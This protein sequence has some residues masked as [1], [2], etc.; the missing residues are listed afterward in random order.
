LF[1]AEGNDPRRD[2]DLPWT[3]LQY[4]LDGKTYGVVQMNSPDNP[5]DTVWS[6][7]RDYGRFGAFP[8]AEIA[9]GQ[10]LTLSYRFLVLAGPLPDR[11]EIQKQYQEYAP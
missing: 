9:G 1:P 6:A 11:D 3:A 5:K 10:S 2:K 7:Y 4:V 8:R